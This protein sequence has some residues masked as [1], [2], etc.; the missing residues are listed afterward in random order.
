MALAAAVIAIIE[1][2]HLLMRDEMVKAA[3][4]T[5][6]RHSHPFTRS[7]Q[8]ASETNEAD[9]VCMLCLLCAE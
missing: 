8:A 9:N 7:R 1:T 6:H 5:R 3:I 2:D 4:G